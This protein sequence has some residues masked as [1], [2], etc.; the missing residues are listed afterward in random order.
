MSGD[1]QPHP[2]GKTME[3]LVSRAGEP[4]RHLTVIRVVT[5]GNIVSIICEEPQ[6]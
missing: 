4:M 2:I 6:A 3:V 1:F 5:E